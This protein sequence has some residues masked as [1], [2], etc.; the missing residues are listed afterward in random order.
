MLRQNHS[1]LISVWEM[2]G[3][4]VTASAVVGNPALPGT[5]D[6]AQNGEHAGSILSGKWIID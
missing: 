1:G 3:T 6:R 4:I 5:S 2:N